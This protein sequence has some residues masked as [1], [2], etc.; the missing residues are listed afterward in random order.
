MSKI[1]ALTVLLMLLVVSI[2]SSNKCTLS[3]RKLKSQI[4]AYQKKCLKRGFPSS[5]GCDSAEDDD[6]LKKK[7]VKK[8]TRM[9]KELK[10]CDYSCVKE[11]DGGWSDFGDWSECS[12]YCEG[13]T[14][15]R[16]RTC[17]NPAPANEGAECEGDAEETR[18]C[19][20]GPCPTYDMIVV[21]MDYL[22]IYLDGVEVFS[23]ATEGM[24]YGEVKVPGSTKVIGLK[25]EDVASTGDYGM[26][27]KVGLETDE[28]KVI[29]ATDMS[30][31]CSS[32]E[33]SGWNSDG[34]TEGDKWTTPRDLGDSI[35]TSP[36]MRNI[37]SNSESGTAYCRKKINFGQLNGGW[38]D[39]GDWSEC[40]AK[41][42][43]GS[44]TRTKTCTNPA[45][46]KGGAD[47]VGDAEETRE[48][49]VEAC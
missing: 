3:K 30:W 32:E 44:Q 7:R 38:S 41:C 37:W 27:G 20:T 6:N 42:G 33:E 19:N 13:G 9:E 40:S 39:Y 18:E 47:C 46:A 17:T 25:C 5:L 34:F 11:I 36:E 35:F 24:T 21:C 49:N 22:T 2:V 16:T 15:T 14:Q 28:E 12:E 43:G 31:R 26:I 29:T 1:A 23:E 8:C 4:K 45:P 48:C 10:S